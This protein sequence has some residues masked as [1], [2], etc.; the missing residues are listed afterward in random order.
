MRIDIKQCF[1]VAK[2]KE[3]DDEDE[4]EDGKDEDD[5]D[6]DDEDDDDVVG[7]R[8]IGLLKCRHE[9][10][11]ACIRLLILTRTIEQI[12]LQTPS[13]TI[14]ESK[15]LFLFLLFLFS[16]TETDKSKSENCHPTLSFAPKKERNWSN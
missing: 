5:D 1:D 8:A 2:S 13:R 4:K 7:G 6:D 12:H 14:F 9:P 16:N 10:T 11:L 15:R 3:E